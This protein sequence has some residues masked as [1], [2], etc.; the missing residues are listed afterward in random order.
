MN[1]K[2]YINLKSTDRDKS[3][4]RILPFD[5]LIEI[6]ETNKMTISSPSKWDDPFENILFNSV[7][8][9]GSKTIKMSLHNKCYAQSWCLNSQSDA[10]WRIYSPN[11]SCVRIKSSIRKLISSLSSAVGQGHTK[12]VFIGKVAYYS[13]KQLIEQAKNLGANILD[14]NPS[15]LAKS[16][17][18]KRR[19]FSHEKE[20]RLIFFDFGNKTEND[21]Y[22][23]DVDPFHLI[24]TV[25]IDP[26]ASEGVV[27]IYKHYLKKEIRF[28]GT[29]MRSTLYDLPKQLTIQLQA[30]SA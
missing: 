22:Q 6:F 14:S 23:Y 24:E 16:L 5:R 8:R 25:V 2:K 15:N 1:A 7:F 3:V 19:A 26:R 13:P 9:Y 4:Y 28:K 29:I 17:L 20:I 21:F 27:K 10:L 30:T 12:G 11:K 18:F